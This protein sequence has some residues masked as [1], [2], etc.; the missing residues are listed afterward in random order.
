MN[1]LALLVLLFF[2][3][4]TALALFWYAYTTF[5]STSRT[6]VTIKAA[7]LFA[8]NN[9]LKL[10]VVNPGPNS[11]NINAV[12]L[13][14]IQCNLTNY[15]YVEPGAV[16]EVDAECP[17][18]QALSAQGILVANGYSIPFVASIS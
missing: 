3:I 10:V 17:R 12:Y 13:N 16:A 4:A 6:F 8:E 18:V 15:V 7:V 1:S 14:G 11:A 2:T 5:L 9:T